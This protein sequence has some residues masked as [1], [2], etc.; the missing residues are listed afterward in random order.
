MK[1]V[2]SKRAG[3]FSDFT[4]CLLLNE[5]G[6]GVI[7]PLKWKQLTGQL[8]GQSEKRWLEITFSKRKYVVKSL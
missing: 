6:H 7:R 8:V 5:Q 2:P 4:V 1:I 3:E